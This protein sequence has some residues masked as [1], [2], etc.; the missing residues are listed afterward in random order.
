MLNGVDLFSGIG[1]LSLA[2]RD[3]VRPLAYCEIDR[4]AQSVLLSRMADGQLYT[5][6]IWDDVRTLTGDMLPALHVDIV[7]GGFPCQDISAAGS[8]TG[9][10][11]KRSGLVFEALRLIKET[12]PAYVFFENVPA[13]RTRGAERVGKELAQLGY[14]SRWGLLSAYDVGAPHRRERWWMLAAHTDSVGVWDRRERITQ[15]DAEASAV[16]SDDGLPRH[17]AG[18]LADSSRE[19][20]EAERPA[21]DAGTVAHG[22]QPDRRGASSDW[23]S[24]EWWSTEPDVVRVVNE[25]PH[26]VD[27]IKCL[28]NGVVPR[29]AK[30]AFERLMGFK[31]G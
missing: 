11:G 24:D 28:G 20:C 4:Y 9:L 18:S 16:S 17:V 6:P 14:D 15:G 12:W 19:R 29:T 27:R 7:Y 26:R 8:R 13:I 3:Y 23:R 30:E 22:N 1:G 2:L 25:C 21:H 5:A 10:E 31:G